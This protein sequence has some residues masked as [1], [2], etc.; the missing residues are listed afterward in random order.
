MAHTCLFM[1]TKFRW[2]LF[3]CCVQTNF[4]L[5]DLSEYLEIT[6]C[7][8]QS[9]IKI[10]H[11][12]PN[13]IVNCRINTKMCFSLSIVYLYGAL[14][15]LSNIIINLSRFCRED[16]KGSQ[17]NF[18]SFARISVLL[19]YCSS[20]TDQFSFLYKIPMSLEIQMKIF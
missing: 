13:P 15:T 6:L 9:I 12:L 4:G 11:I 7:R 2:I 20:K 17:R 19:N 8:I 14:R 3:L 10:S 18:N 5:G 16:Q 1:S